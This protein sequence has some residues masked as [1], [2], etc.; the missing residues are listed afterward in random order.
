MPEVSLS[1]GPVTERT[2]AVS[3][4]ERTGVASSPV[5]SVIEGTD[6]VFTLER[7]GATSEALAVMVRLSESGS[8]LSSRP[9]AAGDYEYL[10][11][12][13]GVGESSATLR[14]PTDDD[15]VVEAPSTVTAWLLPDVSTD[16][17]VGSARLARLTV[18]DNDTATFT[19]FA[20]PAEIAEGETA[21][22][23]VNVEGGVF[24]QNQ[25]ITLDF[26]GDGQAADYRV[27][28]TNNQPL[29]LPYTLILPAGGVAVMA[30]VTALADG[31]AESAETVVV[32][33]RHDSAVIGTANLTIA[34]SDAALENEARLASLSLSDASMGAFSSDVFTYRANVG[35]GIA[36]TMIRAPPVNPR[37]T[38]RVSAT[39]A[40]L[41][42]EGTWVVSLAPGANTI[43]IT[44]TSADRQ[45]GNTYTVTVYRA[46][47]V[48]AWGGR[49]AA[50]DFDLL[51]EQG[52]QTL[53][54]GLWSDREFLWVADWDTGSLLAYSL[55]DK[56]RRPGWDF[57]P[58]AAGSPAGMWSDGRTLWV[59]DYHEGGIYAY[60]MATGARLP[61][62]DI[63]PAQGNDDPTGIWSDG[64]TLWVADYLDGKAYAYGLRDGA[65]RIGADIDF[66]G[67][68]AI[69]PF[70]MWSD[71]ETLW[72]ANW[73]GGELRA[74]R[75]EDGE[76]QEDKD[77]DLSLVG[78]DYP[79]G[80]WSDGAT[81]YVSDTSN[82]RV[83]AYTAEKQLAY[84]EALQA[85][86][87]DNALLATLSLSGVDLGSFSSEVMSYSATVGF[88]VNE[89][90][91]EAVAAD[92]NASLLLSGAGGTSQ[93]GRRTVPL[94][95][96]LNV[97]SITV[98]A[99][100]GSVNTY[101]VVVF[102]TMSLT[103]GDASLS[104]LSLSGINIGN[105]SSTV[106]EYAVAVAHTLETTRVTALPADDN[107]SVVIRA[108]GSAGG[109]EGR[110][111]DVALAQ[112]RNTITITVT[113]PEGTTQTYSVVV[114]RAEPPLPPPQPD[115]PQPK[116]DEAAPR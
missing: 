97:I 103:P 74:Y 64:D 45:A 112:G 93:G 33:A 35:S 38:I 95:V 82:T 6:A 41:Q 111:K 50:G 32:E 34:A 53:P 91:V 101:S 1:V 20:A 60:S 69:H 48:T 28:D 94:S 66:N 13:F 27:A 67:E 3:T 107:A 18:T 19:V 77:I 57:S 36:S 52:P 16:Y 2:G 71:G 89:T 8:M 87:S 40:S 39:G 61:D 14:A 5:T 47:G 54:A 116:D 115:P 70:G 109:T 75:L 96:G 22:I 114:T 68:E 12:T 26:S 85:V 73:I 62:Q 29:T 43:S 59:A 15:A 90:A 104:F 113:A 72:V 46:V 30:A 79:M 65:R 83:Y 11:V 31:E 81:L 51:T 102:R 92:A 80:I 98:T 42:R 76:H 58:L 84:D 21:T 110:Q 88:D 63:S 23:A 49:D 4:L 17:T 78:N 99:Q 105:F 56:A 25:P 106:T 37:A 44:V 10:T 55:A 108:A 24:A 9:T 7:T 86:P 100:T